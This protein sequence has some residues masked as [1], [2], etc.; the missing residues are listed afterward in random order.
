MSDDSMHVEAEKR[1]EEIAGCGFCDEFG[2]QDLPDGRVFKCTHTD[3]P[4][5]WWDR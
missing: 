4:E 3:H 1:R 5:G 2:W